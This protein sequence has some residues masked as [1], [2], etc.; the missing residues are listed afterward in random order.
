MPK[1]DIRAL[2]FSDI[3]EYTCLYVNS[4]HPTLSV[5]KS[6]K[7]ILNLIFDYAVTNGLCKDNFA[8]RI[9]NNNYYKSL[10]VSKRSD[11]KI[12]SV[13]EI[14]TIKTEVRKRMAY[15]KKYNGYFINGY[16]ILLSIETGMRV[17]EICALKWSDIS[18]KD[19]W[20]HAQQL[21]SKTKSWEYCPRL[22][23]ERLLTP[24]K[25]QGSNFPLTNNI[26][27]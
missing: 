5:F 9:K 20:I 15:K 1:K 26:K 21:W 13:E 14:E 11:E 12:F 4:I 23:H 8:R 25:D 3:K 6:Y 27:A 16:A 24:D 18:E 2:T 10:S 22:K 7:G 17:A 19:I